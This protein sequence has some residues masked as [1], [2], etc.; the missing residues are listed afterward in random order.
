[1][2]PFKF[3]YIN[4]T[5]SGVTLGKGPA[6]LFLHG[7]GTSGLIFQPLA[8][9]LSNIRTCYLVDLPG[10]GN[11]P[12]PQNPWCLK[13]YSDIIIAFIAYYLKVSVD[14]IAHSFGGRIILKLLYNCHKDI[15]IRHILITGGAGLKYRRSWLFYCRKNF[16]QILKNVYLLFPR[17][18]GKNYLLVLRKSTLWKKLGSHDYN[19]LENPMRET[20]VSIINESFDERLEAIDHEILLLWGR[21]DTETPL[22]QAEKM[23]KYLPNAHLII[24]EN[25]GHYAFLDA[26]I[27]FSRISYSL[28]SS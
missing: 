17:K 2:E 19:Q 24:I 21:N 13:N 22:Y 8:M 25:A 4:Q 12:P 6:L 5:L 7:W 20:F 9:E 3:N 23:K 26:S 10:F 15:E 28:F 27:T 18:L 11:S 16:A 14:I 1:M